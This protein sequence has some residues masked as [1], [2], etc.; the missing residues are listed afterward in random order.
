M[1]RVRDACHPLI[2]RHLGPAGH[3]LHPFLGLGIQIKPDA[4]V[5][6]ARGQSSTCPPQPVRQQ[7][8]PSSQPQFGALPAMHVR[9]GGQRERPTPARIVV[10]L[11]MLFR[12]IVEHAALAQESHRLLILLPVR[13]S[14]QFTRR[15]RLE[16]G[17]TLVLPRCV[18]SA[19]QVRGLDKKII[20]KQLPAHIDGDHLGR[21][22][23]IGHPHWFEG[24]GIPVAR[25]PHVRKLDVVV[26]R[27]CR[28]R[29]PRQCKTN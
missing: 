23:Q 15:L 8:I 1:Q 14:G 18:K 13:G 22:L 28:G 29:R 2:F 6:P 11:E 21:M 10:H 9:A 20:H 17:I 3:V 27:L 12:G 25:R 19:L 24:T 5:R 26:Q 16:D 7:G 4:V